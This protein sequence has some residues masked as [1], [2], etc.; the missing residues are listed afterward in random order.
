[1]VRLRTPFSQVATAVVIASVSEAISVCTARHATRLPR[2]QPPTPSFGGQVGRSQRRD[3][4]EAVRLPF[5]HSRAGGNP[6]A[7]SYAEAQRI[8][9][10]FVPFVFFVVWN[11]RKRVQTRLRPRC[12]SGRV[13]LPLDHFLLAPRKR[14]PPQ[15]RYLTQVRRRRY[16]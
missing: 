3:D 13:E 16:R 11:S 5:R 9:S 8:V 14:G 10:L 2:S 4:R 6:G 7:Q 12:A 1:M 15:P